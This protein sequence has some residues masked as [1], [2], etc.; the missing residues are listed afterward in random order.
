L[1]EGPNEG[2]PITTMEFSP[3]GRYLAS[4]TKYRSIRIYDLER[5]SEVFTLAGP[6]C[7]NRFQLT[8]SADGRRLASCCW[9]QWNDGG[10]VRVWELETGQ[11][12]AS[13][14]AAAYDKPVA[15]AFSPDGRRL[16][17]ATVPGI[18]VWGAAP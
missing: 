15:L 12:T 3:D 1:L 10:N 5:K 6:A 4:G 7:D 13:F 11:E 2:H 18:K 17:T 14:R 8:F 16:A 9:G